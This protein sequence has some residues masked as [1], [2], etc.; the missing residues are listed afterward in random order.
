M[1][2]IVQGSFHRILGTREGRDGTAVIGGILRPDTAERGRSIQFLSL[3]L[4]IKPNKPKSQRRRGWNAAECRT[5]AI[6]VPARYSDPCA[7]IL[8]GSVKGSNDRAGQ[9]VDIS[10][11]LSEATCCDTVRLLTRCVQPG[12]DRQF[13]D[14]SFLT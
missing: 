4:Q 6:G 12:L 2:P 11:Q 1:S 7:F 5:H 9:F 8:E 3:S 13:R 14:G 10:R